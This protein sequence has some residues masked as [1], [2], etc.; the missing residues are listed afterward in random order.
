MQ[1]KM[2]AR[3]SFSLIL[4]IVMTIVMSGTAMAAM[5]EPLETSGQSAAMGA[6][7][8]E[9]QNAQTQ[10][11]IAAGVVDS[12]S[13]PEATSDTD[14]KTTE[15]EVWSSAAEPQTV[16]LDEDE[17]EAV[18]EMEIQALAAAAAETSSTIPTYAE[19]YEKMMAMKSELPEGMRWTNFEPYGSKGHL[20]ENYYFR[21]GVIKGARYG[22]GCAA[23]CFYMQDTVY[24]D[25]PIRVVDYSP[26]L[27]INDFHIGDFVRIGGHFVTITQITSSGVILAEGNYNS[28][29][30]WG[31]AMS[32]AELLKGTAFFV[33]R[34]PASYSEDESGRNEV[35]ARGTE[36]SLDWTITR[37]GL[38]SIAG[39]GAIGNYDHQNRPSWETATDVSGN[40]CPI[41][42]VDIGSGVT[43]IGNHAF[44]NENGVGL[45]ELVAAYLPD[46]LTSIGDSVFFGS[47]II[48]INIP[49]SVKTIGNSAFRFCG[50]L[51]S[52]HISDGVQTVG[53]RAFQ[54][55]SALGYVDIPGSVKS[56]GSG[57]FFDCT[58]EL[59]Q[60]RFM[61]NKNNIQIGS[62]LFYNCWNLN[63]ISLP[64]GITEIPAGL[65]G[66]C[67]TI[68]Y[69]YIPSS[70]TSL[71][72]AGKADPFTSCDGV[73]VIYFGGNQNQWNNLVKKVPMSLPSIKWVLDSAAVYVDQNDPFVPEENDPGDMQSCEAG[74]HVGPI[75]DG[76]CTNCGE[77][78]SGQP[79]VKPE[80]EH[81]WAG[82]WSHDETGHWHACVNEGCD[83]TDNTEKEGYGEHTYGEW[84]V[85]IEASN[86]VD[87]IQHRECTACGHDQVERLPVLEHECAWS[88]EWS[89]D[90][91]SHWHTCT[92]DGCGIT[93]NSEKNSYGKHD[94]GEWVI[95]T[96][97]AENQEGS[98]YQKCKC[99]YHL[100]EIIPALEHHWSAEW[101]K[102]ET[103]HWIECLNDGCTITDHTRKNGYGEH[104]YGEWVIDK[105]AAA[106]QAG[107]QH[108]EC[109]VCSYSETET[110]QAL[111]I[112]SVGPE[113]SPSPAPLAKGKTFTISKITYKVTKAGA[114]VEL[115]TSKSTA[116][117]VAINTVIGTDG[118]K[119]KVTSIG[120]KAMQNNKKL[121]NL[122]LGANVKTVG[123]N[124]FS[125]CTKLA[126]VTLGKNTTSIGAGA[127]KGCTALKKT[128]T[129][130]DSV[131][132]VGANAFSG[133]NKITAVI[134]GKTSKSGL[135]TIGKSV[136]NGCRKLSKV[137]IRS[138]KLSSVGKQAF[139]GTKSG[140]KV[141]VPS[142]QLTKYKNILKKAGLKASQVTK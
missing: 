42:Q 106:G 34:Y 52:V 54:A 124:A 98:R 3:K 49:A 17:A 90:E 7:S 28:S 57:A 135:K 55:C 71:A 51:T 14:E 138:S 88:E 113:V 19:A 33:T 12:S 127:F 30:H 74:N 136:F 25:L 85:D 29:V 31:R 116:A 66:S 46:T 43:S 8:P 4:A 2:T 45:S 107:S 110:I 63:Y 61:P 134:I 23:F 108:R 130:P 92:N 32:T 67:K 111:P 141:K 120:S 59:K 58:T 48:G 15:I 76:I 50:S 27:K 119:Y 96:E 126:A 60:V 95:E 64:E 62:D 140:L 40:V 80:H 22:V 69:L 129:L 81:D 133:C 82:D 115:K 70:V 101:N 103:G 89:Y 122:T 78:T 139:K 65:F 75:E 132:T 10:S 114:E 6:A 137:T 91:D 128:I 123:A 87:G 39:K 94:Y 97:A 93:D 125:G 100:T 79:P 109:I 9:T 86:G 104:I 142:K 72:E 26:D 83:I 20:G 13:Q 105:A 102:D 5:V 112:P 84:E 77:S 56:I 38:L 44:C 53:E 24:G 37:G 1:S 47:K 35:A 18:E 99:G 118:V 73:G 68:R 131:K 121:K 41:Y 117:K 11:S 21:G 36:G 16:I